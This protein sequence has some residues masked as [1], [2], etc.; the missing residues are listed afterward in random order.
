MPD[1]TVR[2]AHEGVAVAGGRPTRMRPRIDVIGAGV[3]GLA[4]A[5]FLSRSG[6]P[7]DIHVWERDAGVGGLAGSF[8]TEHFSAEKF[9]HHLFR[10]DVALQE[11]ISE[12]GLGSD[13][14]W[15]PALTGA[16]YRQQPYR[17]SSPGDLLRFKPLAVLDRLRLGWLVLH[18]RLHKDWR[19]LD[20]VTVR[21]YITRVA[22]ENVYR[23]VWE[24]LFRGKFGEDA[25]SISAAW[26]WSKL[27]DRGGSRG[28][29][30]REVLGYLR[31]GLGRVFDEL[32]CRLEATGHHVH[33]NAPV[34]RLVS[35][36]GRAIDAIETPEGVFDTDVVVSGVHTPQLAE[37]LPD[38]FAGYRSDLRRIRF[39]ANVCLVLTLRKSLSDFYWTNV[40]D[41]S[42]PFVGIIEQ[43]RWADRSD[44]SNRH[45]AYVSA[46]VPPTDPRL[47]MDAD[48]LLR[49]Y[50][51]HIRR[52]F[53]T[54]DESLVEACHAWRERY[55]QPIVQT[56]YRHLVPE[57]R[58]PVENLYVCT[59]AQ[60]Y[61]ND[62]QVSN[63]VECAR[64]TAETVL[65]RI[66]AETAK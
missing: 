27:V 46:Y 47:S 26:L 54:F 15:R 23:V 59:M 43:T 25:D 5:Y 33:R 9:Y 20:D 32:R 22:G 56:G 50:L 31:G 28:A 60:I 40:T 17:L 52:M 44:F 39:L 30:G 62:R 8:T 34:R 57:V 12:L 55:T 42:L 64:R 19:E 13:L 14:E 35:R 11:L 66:G 63:G 48:E 29:G 6:R 7:L 61:P 58:S 51:P 53:P 3:S 45:V 24:P 49:F 37:L 4:T 38:A 16:Y 10:G 36:A 2:S 41:T 65:A 21:D 18:A 1:P